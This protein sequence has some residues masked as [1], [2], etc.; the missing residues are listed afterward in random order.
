MPTSKK[1]ESKPI[2]MDICGLTGYV[3]D[4]HFAHRQQKGIKN[5]LNPLF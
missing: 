2:I 4:F 3:I 1:S 5:D